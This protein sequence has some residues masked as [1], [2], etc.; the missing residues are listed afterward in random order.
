MHNNTHPYMYV[1]SKS[2][3]YIENGIIYKDNGVKYLTSSEDIKSVIDF[4]THHFVELYKNEDYEE[5]LLREAQIQISMDAVASTSF[6]NN[7]IAAQNSFTFPNYGTYKNTITGK[8]ARLPTN[9]PYVL[10]KEWVGVTKGVPLSP[11]HRANI[12]MGGKGKQKGRKLTQNQIELIKQTKKKRALRWYNDGSRS[13]L[14]GKKDNVPEGFVLG[15]I[16]G[17]YTKRPKTEEHRKNLSNSHK[18][19]IA[20]QKEIV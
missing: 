16:A 14:C 13:I 8:I 6:F 12:S 9:H 4:E 3:S 20:K 19:R 18:A 5:V 10:S 17:E 7:S 15:R 1:G 2:N 11:G